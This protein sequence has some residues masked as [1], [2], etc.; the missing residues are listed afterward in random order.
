MMSRYD[1][2]PFLRLLDSY[3]LRVIG[4]LTPEQEE[5]LRKLEPK[6]GQIYGQSGSWYQIVEQQM[7]FTPDLPAQIRQIW[8]EGS[9]RA[10]AQG[11]SVDPGEFTRQF[12]DA[13]F[14]RPKAEASSDQR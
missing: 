6:L 5:G 12:V 7:A 2:K 1:G 9:A 11:L 10:R 13:N 4:A 14:N 3:V 8:E